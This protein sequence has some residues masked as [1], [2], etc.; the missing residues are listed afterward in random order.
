MIL[1]SSS[2]HK[3]TCNFMQLS[4]AVAETFLDMTHITPEMRRIR[5]HHWLSCNQWQPTFAAGR[6]DVYK[7]PGAFGSNLSLATGTHNADARGARV[8]LAL[9]RG[10]MLQEEAL[11][12][13]HCSHSI[14]DSTHGLGQHHQREAQD[15]EEGQGGK[16]K[17]GIQAAHH[18]LIG[19]EDHTGSHGRSGKDHGKVDGLNDGILGLQLHL[20]STDGGDLVLKELLPGIE[21][22]QLH[23]RQDFLDDTTT[24]LGILGISNLVLDNEVAKEVLARQHHGD[25]TPACMARSKQSISRITEVILHIVTGRC[26]VQWQT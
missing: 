8:R 6:N 15:V 12:T 9:L 20:T 14:R 3:Q 17:G 19:S 5:R 2:K 26:S 1:D 21:L 4:R 23:G 16:G 7:Q 13:V 24:L 25:H 22:D 10:N 11:N 18:H